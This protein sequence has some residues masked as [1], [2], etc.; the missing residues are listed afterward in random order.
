[1]EINVRNKGSWKQDGFFVGRPSPLSNPFM[2]TETQ[3]REIVL[4]RYAEVIKSAIKNRKKH[5]IVPLQK[6][7]YHLIEN[8]KLD[9]I[10][11]CAPKRCHA[12]LIK[13][14]LLNKMHNNYWLVRDCCPTC[15]HGELKIGIYGL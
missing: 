2:I 7:E 11:Y 3:T 13:Q 12:D 4:Q 15:G 8:G 9:L 5:I 6:L 1:M 14:I 10:C